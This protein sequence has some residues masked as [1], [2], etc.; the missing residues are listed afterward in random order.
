MHSCVNVIM[1]MN[2]YYFSILLTSLKRTLKSDRKHHDL[3]RSGMY[4]II[5]ITYK[6]HLAHLIIRPALKKCF[7]P[8]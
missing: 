2:Y 5:N 7:F 6:Y 4:H 8:V 1:C 3:E